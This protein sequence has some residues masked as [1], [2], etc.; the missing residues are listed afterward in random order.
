MQQ[1]PS[2]RSMKKITLRN[3]TTELLKTRNMEKI[4]KAVRKKQETL[5]LN[6]LR[7]IKDEVTAEFCLETIQ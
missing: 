2:T 7:R 5:Y 3:I 6:I 1:I 4:L